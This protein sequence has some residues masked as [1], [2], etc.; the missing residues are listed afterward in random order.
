M[1]VRNGEST[2]QIATHYPKR[3]AK[4]GHAFIL[5]MKEWAVSQDRASGARGR[6]YPNHNKHL[7]EGAWLNTILVND[8]R[9]SLGLKPIGSYANRSRDAVT[10]M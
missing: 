3:H 9:G 4:L 6:V 10:I 1:T 7:R 5:G 2:K 8:P